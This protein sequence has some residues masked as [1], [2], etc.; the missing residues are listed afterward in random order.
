LA[1]QA[2]STAGC[3][4]LL[5]MAD[6]VSPFADDETASLA[7]LF[8]IAL[9]KFLETLPRG[10]ADAA[11]WRMALVL[12]ERAALQPNREHALRAQEAVWEHLS[13]FRANRRQPPKALRILAASLGFDMAS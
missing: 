1:E 4:A 9:T 12:F 8:A 2:T 3:Q 7:L 11:A 5:D 10:S 13:S 6:L